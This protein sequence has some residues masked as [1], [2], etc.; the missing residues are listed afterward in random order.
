MIIM[1]KKQNE[2]N[3]NLTTY[4]SNSYGTQIYP[5]YSG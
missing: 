2:E 5:A 3:F 4:I 1:K